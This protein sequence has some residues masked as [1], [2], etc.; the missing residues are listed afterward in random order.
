MI[1][2]WKEHSVVVGVTLVITLDLILKPRIFIYL[3]WF[4][5]KWQKPVSVYW[6]FLQSGGNI[7][8]IEASWDTAKHLEKPLFGDCFGALACM[9]VESTLESFLFKKF[10]L[11]SLS[12]K[13]VYSS[14]CYLASDTRVSTDISP[15]YV[16][17][18]LRPVSWI[19]P[20]HPT[21]SNS[22]FFYLSIFM[23]YYLIIHLYH[24]VL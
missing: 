24:L 4:F 6:K 13:P 19:Q 18:F 10:Y 11:N 2:T 21:W 22:F 14:C 9:V 8:A 5:F 3:L 7:I 23:T 17:S 15:C 1:A 12:T 20:P 16:A